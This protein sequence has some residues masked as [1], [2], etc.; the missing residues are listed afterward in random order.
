MYLPQQS[1]APHVMG[2]AYRI[3]ICIVLLTVW[4]GR[5]NASQGHFPEP[6]ADF[7]AHQQQVLEYL[8]DYSLPQRNPEEIKLNLPF[9]LKA[10][11]DAPYR[12]KFLLIHGLN[13]SAYVWRDTALELAARGYDVRSILLPGHG[14]SP[15]HQL[16]IHYKEWLTAVR[17]HFALWNID[18]T[19]IYLGGFSLGG[20]LATILALEQPQVKGLFLFSPAYKSKLNHYLRWS[21][22]YQKFRPWIFGGMILEDNPIKYNSIPVNSGT[23]FFNTTR[24]L[25]GKWRFKSLDIPVL[26]I[27]SSDDSVVDIEFVRKKFASKFKHPNKQ[28]MI[29]AA[30]PEQPTKQNELLVDSQNLERRIINQSHLSLMN[31]P[32]N[33]LF[34]ERGNVL[35][36]NGNEYPIFMACMRAKGHWYGAQHT[37]SPDGTPVARTT[38]N[39]KFDRIFESFD[40]LFIQGM[41]PAEN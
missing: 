28:L 18:D 7:E 12:G 14:S 16:D 6:I 22:I 9:Q 27:L 33:P 13:D 36:C 34:G 20:V 26:M 31:S 23:Q 1:L 39:P 5:A 29:Y 19:P 37:P 4:I 2:F 11:Q 3:L 17:K 30:D 40:N 25:A 21:W 24:K 15:V 10:S 35:V 32:N 38:Y 8:L 41:E